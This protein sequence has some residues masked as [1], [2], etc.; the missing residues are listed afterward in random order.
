MTAEIAIMN[1]EAIAMAADSAVTLREERGEKIF[2]SANKIFAL[3]KYQPIGIMIYGSAEFMGVPWEVLVKIYRNTRGK[4][5]FDT[6]QQ[7]AL[8]FVKFL[9]AEKRLFSEAEQKRYFEENVHGYFRFIRNK[10]MEGVKAI[11]SEKGKAT[12]REIKELTSKIIRENHDIWKKAD[13]LPT[14]P[15]RFPN[16]LRK[17]YV[18]SIDEAKKMVFEKLQITKS[19]SRQLTDV[20]VCL[21]AKWPGGFLV[22]NMPGVVVAGF[23]KTDV[24]P[25]LQ[26][27]LL[28][29]VVDGQLKYKK[30]RYLEIGFAAS[31]WIVP[32]AQSEMVHTFMEGVD[33]GYEIAIENDLLEIFNRYPEVIIDNIVAL[34]E[35]EKTNLKNKL[36]KISDPMFQ[37]YRERLTKYRSINFVQPVTGVV[38]MLPKDELAAMAES[39][40]NLTLFKRR[41]S[42]EAET[43][44]GP[45]DVAV[46]SKGDGLI[47]IKR[48][49]YF[50]P[51]LNAQFFANYYREGKNER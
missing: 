44:A 29:G 31:A 24:F 10:I 39:L 46:I 38:A 1:K 2:T 17:K 36:K 28:Q 22:P 50:K 4:I 26:S 34:D 41:V 32:F 37:Q 15:K 6:L 45:I 27:F 20:A 7:H 23:G 21:F 11:I 48:K 5:T 40:V 12:K 9:T 47:W 19:L 18:A 8:D 33:P 42:L 13:L 49:H 51:E 14:I 25:S 30:D 35:S 3:S 16:E 43:V